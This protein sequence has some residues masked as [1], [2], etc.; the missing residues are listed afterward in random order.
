[1][2]RQIVEE[3]DV[4]GVALDER[5]ALLDVLAH[6]HAEQ[7][8]GRGCVVD[9][10]LQQHPALRVHRGLPQLARRHLAETLEALDAASLGIRLPASSPSRL[11][12]VAFLVGVRV[13]DRLL[14]DQLSL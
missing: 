3:A 5:A 2:S 12:P 8:V 6:E 1:M 13:L 14:P 11:S 9:R 7:L 4:L 10:G